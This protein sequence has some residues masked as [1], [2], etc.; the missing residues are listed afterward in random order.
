LHL[1]GL[2]AGQR[3]IELILQLPQLHIGRA[4]SDHGFKA[5]SSGIK[6]IVDAAEVFRSANERIAERARALGVEGKV[7][8][9]CEC[10]D[11]RCFA[12]IRLEAAEYVALRRASPGFI[13]RRGHRVESSR[14]A[15]DQAV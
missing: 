11:Q 15:A 8:F 10:S 12:L 5:D 2:T 13:L 14:A 9:L 3:E 1:L 4:G 7:P 6:P